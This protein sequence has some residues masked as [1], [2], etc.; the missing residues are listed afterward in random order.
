MLVFTFA[1]EMK[2]TKIQLN[3]CMNYYTE[4]VPIKFAAILMNSPVEK[5]LAEI[6]FTVLAS[7]YSAPLLSSSP[8]L[9]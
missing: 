5:V 6:G 7:G 2:F 8:L 1:Y 3:W 9:H 4:V